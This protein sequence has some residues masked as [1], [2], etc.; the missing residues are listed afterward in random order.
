MIKI[1]EILNGHIN[2]LAGINSEISKYRI[3]N[4]CKKCDVS[5][6]EKNRFSNKCLKSKGGC[7]CNLKAKTSLLDAKCPVGIWFEETINYDKLKKY[8]RK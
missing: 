8:E 6:N 4:A 7:G 2:V 1:I 3:E 5:Y